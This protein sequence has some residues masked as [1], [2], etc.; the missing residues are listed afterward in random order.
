MS[1]SLGMGF[2]QKNL[3]MWKIFAKIHSDP[4]KTPLIPK[5]SLMEN[6]FLPNKRKEMLN[7]QHAGFITA[8]CS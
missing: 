7:S 3:R 2:T 4:Q 8:A 6:P 5:E 1:G